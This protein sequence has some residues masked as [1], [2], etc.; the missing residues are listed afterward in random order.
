M[1]K[2]VFTDAYAAVLNL[3]VAL[4][5]E[6]GV[7]QVELAGRLGK[8]QQFVS[9]VERGDRRVD[10]VEFCVIVRAIG[11]DPRSTFDRLLQ[12]FPERIDI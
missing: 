5:R 11:A 4:R 1:P 8:P 10:I 2:S 9:K 3:L 7:T 6:H 12:T